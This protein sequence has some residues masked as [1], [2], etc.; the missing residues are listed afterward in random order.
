[1]F[2]SSVF[3]TLAAIA[4]PPNICKATSKILTVVGLPCN[5]PPILLHIHELGIHEEDTVFPVV[6]VPVTRRRPRCMMCGT[7]VLL[8]TMHARRCVNQY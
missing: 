1:M 5:M 2:S 3:G 7:I 6:A 4:R 8:C